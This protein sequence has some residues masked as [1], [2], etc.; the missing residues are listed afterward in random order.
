MLFANKRQHLRIVDLPPGLNGKLLRADIYRVIGDRI[1][2][3]PWAV[4]EGPVAKKKD[5][6]QSMIFA[7]APRESARAN[8]LKQD[9][10]IPGGSYVIR[11]YIDRDG[12]TH[13][14]RDY[15]MGEAEFFGRVRI[16]GPWKPGY[17]EP[18]IVHAPATD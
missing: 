18:K 16:H 8:E 6:W 9:E 12:K 1:S 7:I 2:E 3:Y 15:E 14:N 17:K 11:I 5:M 10:P 13:H 4:G